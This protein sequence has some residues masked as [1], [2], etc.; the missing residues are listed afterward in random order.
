[1]PLNS[2]IRGCETGDLLGPALTSS[3]EVMTAQGPQ[4]AW[5]SPAYPSIPMLSGSAGLFE[6]TNLGGGLPPLVL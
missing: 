5:L 4:A 1:V 3:A 2:E 6:V